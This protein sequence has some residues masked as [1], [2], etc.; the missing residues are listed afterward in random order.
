MEG[1]GL[2]RQFQ[3][4]DQVVEENLGQI[5]VVRF[6]VVRI[7]IERGE[8]PV[9]NGVRVVPV[10][11]VVGVGLEDVHQ[12]EMADEPAWGL[13]GV[14]GHIPEHVGFDVQ[15]EATQILPDGL[16]DERLDDEMGFPGAGPA[17]DLDIFVQ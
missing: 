2:D 12:V 6:G 7:V 17:D 13:K 3:K 14:I 10:K 16:F 15:D 1:D 9:G 4:A 11:G 5:P 8:S